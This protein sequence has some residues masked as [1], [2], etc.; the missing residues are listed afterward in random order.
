MGERCTESG[1]VVIEGPIPVRG[2]GLRHLFIRLAQLGSPLLP[3]PLTPL[4][5]K[6]VQDPVVG[7]GK[8]PGFDRGLSP[9]LHNT[10]AGCFKNL[11][12]D[13]LS[14]G[15]LAITHT[16]TIAKDWLKIGFCQ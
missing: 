2:R 10:A 9:K 16:E 4:A 12:C 11:L 14:E 5:L 8:Q 3:G 6:G 7:D 15:C 13:F 1:D